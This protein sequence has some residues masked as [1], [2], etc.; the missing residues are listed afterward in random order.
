MKLLLV[1]PIKYSIPAG[2]I[3]SNTT[4]ISEQQWIN[5]QSCSFFFFS[6]ITR[7][8]L[9][10]LIREGISLVALSSLIDRK[11]QAE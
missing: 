3:V 8:F 1:L 9:V 4:G 2:I 10:S 7:L 5:Y 11:G 6:L